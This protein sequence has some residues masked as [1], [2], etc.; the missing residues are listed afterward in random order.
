[1]GFIERAAGFPNFTKG[2]ISVWFGV[3]AEVLETVGAVD[4]NPV[5]GDNSGWGVY[6]VPPLHKIVPI[7]VFGS[8]EINFDSDPISPSYIGV[9]CAAEDESYFTAN[10]QTAEYA[11]FTVGPDDPSLERRPACFTMEGYGG[12]GFEEDSLIVTPGVWHHALIFIDITPS[13]SAEYF[14][15]SGPPPDP[16][17]T[18]TPGPTFSWAFDDVPKMNLSM[19]P[20]GGAKWDIDPNYIIPQQLISAVAEAD[21]NGQNCTVSVSG[22]TI[23]Q[24]GNPIGTPS[25]TDYSANVYQGVFVA[26]MQVF[27]DVDGDASDEDTRRKFIR[28][29]GYP[30][31]PSVAAAFFGKSPEVYFQTHNDWITGNN[32]GTAGNFTPTGTITAYS[33]DPNL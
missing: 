26:E 16:A 33:N 23:V 29:N 15:T 10:F 4:P 17:F 5:G 1:M 31:S 3:P 24:S 19:A 14:D 13:V 30:A 28:S 11:S 9:N 8:Q 7:L 6:F 18:I 25:T 32:R 20:S 21:T 27:T 12:F 22:M 2:C